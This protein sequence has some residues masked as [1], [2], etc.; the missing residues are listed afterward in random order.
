MYDGK[1]I[2]GIAERVA[3]IFLGAVIFATVL[4]GGGFAATQKAANFDERRGV[5]EANPRTND[6][7]RRSEGAQLA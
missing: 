7:A 2:V 5:A 1:R 3:A 4:P 6:F